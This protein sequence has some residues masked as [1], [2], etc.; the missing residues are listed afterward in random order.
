MSDFIIPN[1]FIFST[2]LVGTLNL[3]VPFITKRH[4]KLRDFLLIT[5]ATAFFFNILIIDSSFFNDVEEQ[6]TIF[7]FGV[8]DISLHMEPIGLIFLN[9]LGFLWIFALIYTI[10]FLKINNFEYTNRF[11]FFMNACILCGVFIALSANLLTM[12]IGYEL[13]T[14]CTLPL[15]AHNIDKQVKKGLTRYVK[16]LMITALALF[17]PAIIAIY[18]FVGHGD[19]IMGGIVKGYVSDKVA[20]FLLL[21]FIF[22][23]SKAALFP[24]QKWL[25][26]AM[27]ASYPV[28]ALLHAVV[29]V[30]TGLFCIYKIFVYTFGLAYLQ[31]LFQEFNWLIILPVI[32]IFYSSFQALR[33]DQIKMILAYSTINQLS[34]ALLGAFLMTS[35]GIS[36]SILHMVSHSF[37][38]IC[39]FYSAGILY[40]VRKSY[41]VNELAGIN[42]IMHLT[43]FVFLISGLSLIGIPPLAG[44]VSKF[45]IMIAAAEQTNIIC[46][47]TL[48]ISA[49][50]SSIYMIKILIFVYK[51]ISKSYSFSQKLAPAFKNSANR[52][53]KKIPFS[54]LLSLFFC[55]SGVIFFIFIQQLISKF[56]LY[57]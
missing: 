9:L 33:Y 12:F 48:A 55:L 31:S 7:S 30:K 50:F 40:T 21:M 36:A 14:I 32:T 51:P 4:S 42:R 19:F 39:L 54:M 17:L 5:V 23:I 47:I 11:L 56:L 10:N 49:L 38:K 18:S 26:A 6:L 45:Y 13:L 2:I 35:K 24:M 15:I 22:G 28:S 41:S 46:M 25:P 29:V 16:I 37:T 27:V 8:F 34:I 20:I 44:F 3:I 57:I 52:A 53:E 1:M 43:S